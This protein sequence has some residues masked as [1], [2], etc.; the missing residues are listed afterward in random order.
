MTFCIGLEWYIH[1]VEST[2]T[3]QCNYHKA[4]RSPYF[5]NIYMLY[6]NHIAPTHTHSD[7]WRPQMFAPIRGT[8][9]WHRPISGVLAFTFIGFP[10]G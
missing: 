2:D 9:S 8:G 10:L 3:S 6:N 7:L 1:F 5:Y 4:R